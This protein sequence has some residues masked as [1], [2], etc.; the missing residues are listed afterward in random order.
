MATVLSYINTNYN[1][2]YDRTKTNITQ[3]LVT[4][5]NSFGKFGDSCLDMTNSNHQGI[6]FPSG[7]T[8]TNEEFTISAWIKLSDTIG[9]FVFIGNKEDTVD[10]DS[11]ETTNSEALS[12]ANAGVTSETLFSTSSSGTNL[13]SGSIISLDDHNWHHFV[14]VRKKT[15]NV[16]DSLIQFVDGQKISETTIASSRAIDFSKLV[17][18]CSGDSD[19]LIGYMDD[20]CFIKGECLWTDEFTSPSVPL[21]DDTNLSI[22]NEIA[23]QTTRT[24]NGSTDVIDVSTNANIATWELLELGKPFQLKLS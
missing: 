8:Y 21:M 23:S 20:F 2:I 7:V 3:G 14:M 16:D 4:I 11:W 24:W 12:D 18:G 15:A 9:N 10:V 1:R 19:S 17:I 6:Y 22:H 13:I 5:D